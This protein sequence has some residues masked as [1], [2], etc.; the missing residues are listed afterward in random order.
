MQ[1]GRGHRADLIEG[2][3]SAVGIGVV[4]DTSSS[5]DGDPD[6]GARA[7]E[8]PFL[9]GV[10]Y[11]DRDGDGFYSMREGLNRLKGD[12]EGAGRSV[13]ADTGGYAI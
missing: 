9:L 6:F 12:V 11:R 5:T 7:G 4:K 8:G 2:G 13:G 3:F 10:A 1:A